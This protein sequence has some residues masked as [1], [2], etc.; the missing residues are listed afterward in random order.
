MQTSIHFAT[1]Y[2]GTV[3]IPMSYISKAMY[4]EAVAPTQYD[5]KDSETGLSFQKISSTYVFIADPAC[6]IVSTILKA[7]WQVL[8]D[9]SYVGSVKF[10]AKGASTTVSSNWKSINDVLQSY[11]WLGSLPI[12]SLSQVYMAIAPINDSSYIVGTLFTPSQ[13]YL[14]LTFSGST[15]FS[16]SPNT[17]A[18]IPFDTITDSVGVE[19]TDSGQIIPILTGA[20]QGKLKLSITGRYLIEA[21]FELL[22]SSVTVSGVV[23]MQI[24]LKLNGT[25]VGQGFATLQTV[26][27]NIDGSASIVAIVRVKASDLSSV[28]YPGNAVLEVGGLHANAA[29]IPLKSSAFTDFN[30]TFLG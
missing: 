30:I 26:S 16:L 12:T 18:Q 4:Q 3:K 20:D 6:P 10:V 15:P 2:Q 21:S 11:N 24:V 9:T 17:L 19:E 28:T 25:A 8:Y 7:Q 22:L 14:K 27:G 29:S 13:P 23:P 5:Y 1:Y